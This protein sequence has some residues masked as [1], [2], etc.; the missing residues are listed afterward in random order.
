MFDSYVYSYAGL[1]SDL[2]IYSVS[3]IINLSLVFSFYFFTDLP[4]ERHLKYSIERVL[5]DILGIY[6]IPIIIF[7]NIYSKKLRIL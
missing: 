6:L 7:L 5:F 3:L 1:T 4:I 2:S